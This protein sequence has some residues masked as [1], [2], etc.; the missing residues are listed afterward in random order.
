[1]RFVEESVNSSEASISRCKGRRLLAKVYFFLLSR[2]ALN[3][4]YCIH[5]D[6]CQSRQYQIARRVE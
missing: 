2:A 5:L 3:F 4:S 1:M 6:R